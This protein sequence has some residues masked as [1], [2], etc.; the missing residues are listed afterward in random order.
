GALL[1]GAVWPEWGATPAPVPL[2]RQ[3]RQHGRALVGQPRDEDP[4]AAY[5]V[6][7][8]DAGTLTWHRVPY[9]VRVTQE[10]I[11]R[12]GLPPRLAYRLAAG[13]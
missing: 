6:L 11:L 12:A 1:E 3:L 9:P 13:L 8:T 7:D 4:R 10:R 2:S 5:L